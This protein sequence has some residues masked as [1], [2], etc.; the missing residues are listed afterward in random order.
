MH[1]HSGRVQIGAGEAGGRR[2][3]GG[4]V[5]TGGRGQESQNCKGG[6][7]EGEEGDGRETEGDGEEEGRNCSG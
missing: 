6:S 7:R 1:C 5:N 3:G 2:P 4:P